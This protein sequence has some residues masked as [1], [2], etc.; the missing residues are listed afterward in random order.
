[1]LSK[2]KLHPSY[3]AIPRNVDDSPR[4]VKKKKND[5]LS[6]SQ[7]SMHWVVQQCEIKKKKRIDM[8]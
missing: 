6:N 3:V 4:F 1:M 2:R 7:E 8:H 5:S